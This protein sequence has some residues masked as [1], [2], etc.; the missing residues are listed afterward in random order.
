MKSIGSCL[1]AGLLVNASAAGQPSVPAV[2]PA[3][4]PVATPTFVVDVTGRFSA[5]EDALYQRRLDLRARTLA[6]FETYDTVEPV[7]GAARHRPLPA[8][9]ARSRSIAPQALDAAAAYAASMP[10]S[11]LFVWHRE[12][13]QLERH[14]GGRAPQD[15]ILGRSLAKP[16]AA[17]AIGRA[18]ALGRIRSLEQ[19]VAE[20]LPEWRG[21]PRRSRIRIHHLLDGTAGFLPQGFSVRRE[22]VLNLAFL[23]PRHDEIIVHDYPVVAEPGSEFSYNNAQFDLVAVLVERATG[24]RYHEFVG[25]E[26]LRPIGAAGGEVWVNRPGGVAHAGCCIQLPPET[27]L[28]LGVLLAQDGQW[29]GRRLLP[30]GFVARMATGTPANP[31][32][33]LGVYVAGPYVERRGWAGPQRTPPALQ[34]LHSEPYLARDLFL[35]DGNGN[36]VMYIVP[37]ERLVILRTGTGPKRPLEWDNSRL[38]NVLMRGIRRTT[39]EQ[40]LVPQARRQPGIASDAEEEVVDRRQQ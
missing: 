31:H 12:R 15:P 34:V 6:D 5:A 11:A 35:F 25:E 13:L 8:A 17:I 9:T 22:D 1:L 24:R 7:P 19:P 40:P 21:D 23:H 10:S 18:I 14:F 36:Q 29:S 28:R 2:S 3:A 20:L 4:P 39:G 38:P 37:S 30:R 26:L 32:Y 16:L 33:G 27:W